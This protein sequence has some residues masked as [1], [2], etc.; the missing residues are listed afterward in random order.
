MGSVSTIA[1]SVT[2]SILHDKRGKKDVKFT[3]D[4]SANQRHGRRQQ[5]SQ[6]RGQQQQL[7]H[8]FDNRGSQ[9]QERGQ[10]QRTGDRQQQP[11]GGPKFEAAPPPQ[12][13]A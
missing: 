12:Q 5:Q 3:R 6:G 10:Q 11:W 8:G 4:R 7:C 1:F 9:G 2:I 13:S